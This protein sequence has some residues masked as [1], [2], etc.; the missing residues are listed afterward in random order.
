MKLCAF[1]GEKVPA[2]AQSRK[3]KQMLSEIY[4]TLI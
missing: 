4:A 2:K 1:A 3:G